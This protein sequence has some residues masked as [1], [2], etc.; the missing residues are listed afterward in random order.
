MGSL[1]SN[2]F[3]TYSSS[4]CHNFSATIYPI[5]SPFICKIFINWR[6]KRRER[7]VKI[8]TSK[9]KTKI[10]FLLLIWEGIESVL[11]PISAA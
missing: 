8:Q 10:L 5:L 3:Y 7:G 4:D 9:L 6:V 11:F 2:I 1:R